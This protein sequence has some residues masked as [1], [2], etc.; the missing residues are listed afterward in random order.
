[1]AG[2][3]NEKAL[4]QYMRIL[5]LFQAI[6]PTGD[7]PDAIARLNEG[8][9]NGARFQTLEGVTGRAIMTAMPNATSHE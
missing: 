2:R 7:Q 3:A 8:L 6:E 9:K 4:C 5:N 1:V